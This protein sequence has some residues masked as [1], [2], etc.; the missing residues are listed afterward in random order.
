MRKGTEE[1][2]NWLK[3]KPL[4]IQ[5]LATKYPPGRYIM[6]PGAP[7]GISCE[8]TKVDLYSYHENG[9]VSVVVMAKDKTQAA[10]EYEKE[11]CEQYKK[12]PEEMHLKDILVNID[13]V[14]MEPTIEQML[15]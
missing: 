1:F 5:E 15:N 6:K 4:I 3:E 7:Y 11:L 14:W 13:P 8:G 12:D 9:T 10:I 2:K